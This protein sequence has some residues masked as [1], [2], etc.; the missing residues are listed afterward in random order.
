MGAVTGALGVGGAIGAL[1][2]G[3]NMGGGSSTST[4]TTT[5]SQRVIS[6]PPMASVSL[7]PQ[8]IG[9]GHIFE[10]VGRHKYYNNIEM[11]CYDYFRDK[12]QITKKKNCDEIH[13]DGLKR[14]EKI[15]IPQMENVTPLSVHLTYSS[16]E[17]ISQ[18]HNMRVNFYWRQIMGVKLW[19]SDFWNT[20]DYRKCP[21][22][23]SSGNPILV[24]IKK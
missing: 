21:L 16:D 11:S 23:F 24:N 8:S 4:S 17:M 2:G 19:S 6:I 3:V 20:F 18:P 9:R 7:E 13:F 10:A 22:I 14:G 5:Y 15:D 1:A 12:G